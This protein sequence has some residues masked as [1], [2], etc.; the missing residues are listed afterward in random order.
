MIFR[1]FTVLVASFGVLFGQAGDEVFSFSAA[2]QFSVQNMH[3]IWA[4]IVSEISKQTGKKIE[5]KLYDSIPKF[6]S[7]IK[8]GEIDFAF[9]NPYIVTKLKKNAGYEPIVRDSK[10]LSGLLLVKKDSPIKSVKELEGKTLVFPTPTAL[11]ASLLV[12]AELREK[13]GVRFSSKYVNSHTNVYLHILTNKSAAG[14]SVN[15]ALELEREDIKSGLRVLYKTASVAPHPIV[16]HKRVS[17]EMSDSFKNAIIS[18]ALNKN[19]VGMMT[20]AQLASPVE[21]LYERDYLPIDRLKLE[22]YL[23]ND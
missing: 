5:L 21:A 4:P 6:E 9:V 2:P 20:K 7:A 10:M 13:E 15:K 23:G 22:K 18:L 12:R 19:F 16:V 17:K 3:Q 11:A 14:G 8:A 1:L